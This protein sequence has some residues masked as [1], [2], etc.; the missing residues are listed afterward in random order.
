MNKDMQHNE[1][2]HNKP[3][4]FKEKC[5]GKRC[6][7]TLFLTKGMITGE[8]YIKCNNPKCNYSRGLIP[9]KLNLI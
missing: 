7:G 6:K 9:T 2:Y 1:K 3:L 5:P 4:G 8:E